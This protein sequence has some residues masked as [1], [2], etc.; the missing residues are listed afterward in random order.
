M[1][2]LTTNIFFYFSVAALLVLMSCGS[3]KYDWRTMYKDQKDHAYGT[4]ILKRYLNNISPNEQKDISQKLSKY[5]DEENNVSGN[6]FFMGDAMLVDESDAEAL[7]KFVSEGNNAFIST[8]VFPNSISSKIFTPCH[9]IAKED[10]EEEFYDDDSY[11]YE[12]ED[13]LVFDTIPVKEKMDWEYQ[14]FEHLAFNSFGEDVGRLKLNLDI[15]LLIETDSL[16]KTIKNG[17]PRYHDWYY[18]HDSLAC[19]DSNR[20][21]ILGYLNDTLI[22]YFKI[23]YGDGSFFIHTNPLVF[24]NIHMLNDNTAEYVELIA[25]A[26]PEVDWHWDDYSR[27]NRDMGRSRNRNNSYLDSKGPL[28]YILK[29]DSLRWAW[30]SLLAMG[31]FFLVFKAKRKQR[32]V[33]VLEK[34]ENTSLTFINSIGNLYFNKNDRKQLCE[35][36]MQLW[37]EDIRHHYRINTSNLGD[38]FVSLLAAKTKKT[39]EEIKGLLDYYHNIE[40]SDF[41]SENTMVTFYQKLNQFS[42][43]TK[44]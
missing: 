6:Y 26:K 38:D 23:P 13:N 20:I 39:K 2:K 40:N 27:T 19:L 24:T 21:R 36:Q 25:E 28:T 42:I 22:N 30:Y 34:K 43:Q 11:Y 37:L 1:K 41:V 44:S 15:N 33:P 16:Y 10:Y 35:D 12:E 5:F 17:K 32:I 8:R 14:D 4:Y 7:S 18:L 3:N 31:G 9:V 29:Q